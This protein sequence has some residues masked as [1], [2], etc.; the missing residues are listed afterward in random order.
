MYKR[1]YR[2][3]WTLRFSQ[4]ELRIGNLDETGNGLAP[5]SKN[6][7]AGYYPSGNLDPVVS[8]DFSPING[9]FLTLQIFSNTYLEINELFVYN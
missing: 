3:D 5:F 8:F 9:K 4:V 1:I 7:L 2:D 6:K